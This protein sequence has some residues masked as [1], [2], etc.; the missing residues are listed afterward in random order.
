MSRRSVQFFDHT[1]PVVTLSLPLGRLCHPSRA[2]AGWKFASASSRP[3][4][5]ARARGGDK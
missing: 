5:S 3:P 2:R 4:L 1:G